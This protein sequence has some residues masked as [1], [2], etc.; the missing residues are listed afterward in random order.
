V[1]VDVGGNLTT[2]VGTGVEIRCTVTG[3]PTPMVTWMHNGT[4]VEISSVRFINKLTKA[5]TL[6]GVTLDDIGL[7]TCFANNTFGQVSESSYV[8]IFGKCGFGIDR[9]A[10]CLYKKS[11][12][13]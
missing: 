2:I 4:V 5:F 7:Y 6:L 3:E 11:P 12:Y 13:Y 10:H 8:T 1:S 9:G